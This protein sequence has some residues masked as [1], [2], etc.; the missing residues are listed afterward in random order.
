MN[1]LPVLSAFGSC[2]VVTPCT[3]LKAAGQIRLNQRNI[4]GFV[5]NAPEILQQFRIVTGDMPLSSRLRPYLNIPGHWQ[6]PETAPLEAFH[7]HFAD[8]DLFV[9]E[10]SSIRLLKFKSLFLQIHRT[11]ELLAPDE[12]QS[13]WWKRLL[14]SG[15]NRIA[16]IL[17]GLTEPVQ[18]E[19]AS[20]LVSVEQTV[21]QVE[22]DAL[23]ILA[24]LKKPVLFVTL[25][26][27]DYKGQPIPQR[28][29]IA[30]ALA[31][32]PASPRMAIF[33]PT[34]AV[35]EA[36]LPAAVKDLGHYTEAFEHQIAR[37]LMHKVS[38]L[39][40]EQSQAA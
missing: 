11:R 6:P 23:R 35:L 21:E 34:S 29:A 7:A 13:G 33:D 2:R 22:R 28:S 5:H 32:L 18:R 37:L 24:F 4:Y 14:R 40:R 17:P 12:A 9:V 15:E 19:V 38:A 10:I 1:A 16:E 39:L 26:N 8:T 30:E 3:I 31:R 25:F 20:G 36:G 27:C